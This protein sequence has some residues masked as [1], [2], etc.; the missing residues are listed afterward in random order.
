MAKT[1]ITMRTKS[2]LEDACVRYVIVYING[3]AVQG[4][5]IYWSASKVS[6]PLQGKVQRVTPT[7]PMQVST[8][9]TYQTSSLMSPRSISF[10]WGIVG[11]FYEFCDKLIFW[12][13]Y[14]GMINSMEMGDKCIFEFSSV[15]ASKWYTQIHKMIN[16]WMR[17]W[18]SKWT[19]CVGNKVNPTLLREIIY[20]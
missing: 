7:Y 16:G 6:I 14:L 8:V 9:W 2:G 1:N 3:R 10:M 5:H 20:M 15:R 12:E 19:H 4:Y 13:Y 18:V 11:K 17:N